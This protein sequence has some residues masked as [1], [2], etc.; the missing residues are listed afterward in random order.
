M[1]KPLA[2]A[3]LEQRKEF[4]VH[5]RVD[6]SLADPA[7]FQR[8]QSLQ[9]F[10]GG[11]AVR[12]EVVI[13]EEDQLRAVPDFLDFLDDLPDRSPTVARMKEAL[14]GAEFTGKFAAPPAS[15]SPMGK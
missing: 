13:H 9:K 6:A 4:Q 15:T 3:R 14:D 8:D 7:D 2:A 10:P 12:N 1:S 11:G 5:R